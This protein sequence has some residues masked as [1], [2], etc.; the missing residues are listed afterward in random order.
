MK[1]YLLATLALG[2]L[3]LSKAQDRTLPSVDVKDINGKAFNTSS[4]LDT[5]H[6]DSS[7][8]FVIVSFWATW[9]GPCIKE[10]EAINEKYSEWQK[11][12]KCKLVAVSIDD[13]RSVS[14]VKPKVNG[15]GWNYQILLDEN[16]DFAREM[17]VSDP[18]ALYVI[19]AKGNIVY[20]H[21]GYTPGSEDELEEKLKEL[22]GK[23]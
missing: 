21:L 4:M 12:Y 5:T 8:K 3:T 6:T 23:Q 1:K 9:C 19:D 2:F 17:G 13:A 22:T 11:A 14:K 15:M 10:L 20:S 16:M 7:A 18:P